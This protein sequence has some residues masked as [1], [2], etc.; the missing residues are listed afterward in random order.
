[1]L[2]DIF[3]WNDIKSVDLWGEIDIL[4]ILNLMTH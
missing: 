4:T 2:L 1:M 3:D